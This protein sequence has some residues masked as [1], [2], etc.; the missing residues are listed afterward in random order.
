MPQSGAEALAGIGF[1]FHAF[2]DVNLVV[3]VRC[4]AHVNHVGLFGMIIGLCVG[5]CFDRFV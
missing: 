2:S 1:R 4:G 5:F 3:G